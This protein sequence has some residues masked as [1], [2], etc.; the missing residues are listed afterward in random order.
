MTRKI[1]ITGPDRL[2]IMGLIEDQPADARSR[3]Y[4]RDLYRDL[5]HANIVSSAKLPAGI[6]AANS[7][8][9]LSLDSEEDTIMLVYPRDANVSKNM[10]SVLS[11]LGASIFGRREGDS[12][13]C[14]VAGITNIEIRKVLGG[15]PKANQG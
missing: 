6:V 5:M 1:Y 4:I 8:V 3:E 15:H 14:G 11:P 2:K 10:I 9:L 7:R 13:E 12:F